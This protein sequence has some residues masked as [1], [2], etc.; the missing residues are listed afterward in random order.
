MYLDRQ[1]KPRW[2]LS[3]NAFD[4]LL[5][6]LAD[7]REKAGESYLLLRRNLVRFFEARGL[8][9]SD[10]HADQVLD[11][12]A[13]KL[14]SGEIIENANTYALGI[15]RMYVLE[16]RKAPESKL[17][18]DLPEI[19]TLPNNDSDERE[20]ELTC[21]DRCLDGMPA[22]NKALV[23]RYYS[24]QTREKI[25]N[26]RRLCDEL[27]IAPH[28]LRNRMVR[29]REKLEACISKCLSHQE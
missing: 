10:D 23:T 28:A 1:A 3:G 24:G 7:D 26:R 21:V 19:A 22:E 4:G 27:G 15:A 16:L 13:R 9:S 8:N 2:Q 29:L 11:R 25:E 14:E 6:S 12:L 17:T 5:D 20:R 18:Y